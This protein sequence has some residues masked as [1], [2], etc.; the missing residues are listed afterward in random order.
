MINKLKKLILVSRPISWPNT[1]Y[2]FAAGYLITGGNIN[3]VLILATIF[4]IFPYN[5]L[6]YGINDVFDYESDILNPRKGGIEGM[7][8]EKS[9]HPT[10]IK[11]SILLNLPFVIF[12]LTQSD[13]KAKLWFIFLI[14]MVLAYSFAKLRFKEVPI[15]DSATSS[16]HFVGPLIY[17]LLLTGW[18]TNY[19][20]YVLA[21]FLWGMASHALGAVQ[22]IIPDRKGKISSIAT[23]L[24]ARYT[25]ILSFLF[26]LISSIILIMQSGYSLIVGVAGLS[27]CINIINYLKITDK[28][29]ASIN[30]AWRR[31]I[32]LNL[33]NGFIITLVLIY[34]YIY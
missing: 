3:I 24:G 8:E 11:A 23:K 27:Y 32:Y 34:T 19:L 6:M 20:P 9:L 10:I 12:L 13:A 16:T 2:P 4:F 17:A 28:T 21:F 1:A 14:F 26:Y 5:L 31:F 15:L 7:R 30:K 18:Q 33:F 29:S 22:D 25:T